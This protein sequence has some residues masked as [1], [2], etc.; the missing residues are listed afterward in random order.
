[1]D[2]ETE[3]WEVNESLKGAQRTVAV[4][5][6]EPRAPSSQ[7]RAPNMIRRCDARISMRDV[8]IQMRMAVSHDCSHSAARLLL[9]GLRIK[10]KRM[11]SR[12][13]WLLDQASPEQGIG[14]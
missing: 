6:I 8:L 14:S 13:Q 12:A 10:A 1:M 4:A 3:T 11:L 9:I 7:A 2:E 5:G